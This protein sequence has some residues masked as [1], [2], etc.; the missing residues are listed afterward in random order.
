MEL[1]PAG[2]V[3][4]AVAA[5]V[6]HA[7]GVISRHDRVGHSVKCHPLDVIPLILE[8]LRIVFPERLLDVGVVRLDDLEGLGDAL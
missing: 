3:R 8:V 6:S 5:V 2:R 7:V 4:E 1:H